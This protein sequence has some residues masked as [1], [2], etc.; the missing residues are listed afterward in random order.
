MSDVFVSVGEL[1]SR[2]YRQ[3]IGD[4]AALHVCEEASF[5]APIGTSESE[6]TLEYRD[7]RFNAGPEI[8]KFLKHPFAFDHV[9]DLEATP[10]R[11]ADV[12]DDDVDSWRRRE[13]CDNGVGDD[14]RINKR[15]FVGEL[16][17]DAFFMSLFRAT[18]CNF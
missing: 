6:S 12:F 16:G 1:E 5:T 15:G 7:I 8:T 18:A 13:A 11:E 14:L 4:D 9:A 2:Q 17:S 10:F 3:V